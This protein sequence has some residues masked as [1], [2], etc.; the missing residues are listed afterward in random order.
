[1]LMVTSCGSFELEQ[2]MTWRLAALNIWFVY[3]ILAWLRCQ[4]VCL[5]VSSHAP[6]CPQKPSGWICP[7]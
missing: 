6:G 3:N 2:S 5:R 1:M 7:S 4:G